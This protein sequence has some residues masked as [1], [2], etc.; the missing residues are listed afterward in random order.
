MVTSRHCTQCGEVDDVSK[1]QIVN[2][3]QSQNSSRTGC[4][5]AGKESKS[6]HCLPYTRAVRDFRK[7]QYG[8]LAV[9]YAII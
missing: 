4:H 1:F 7:I 3:I 8:I 2:L 5:K 9:M 6:K